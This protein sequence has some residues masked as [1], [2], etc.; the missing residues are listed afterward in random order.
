VCERE[1]LL[2]FAFGFGKRIARREKVGVQLV[3]AVGGVSE[4]ADL[5]CCLEG[6]AHHI[7]AR[8]DMSRPGH[9]AI[10]KLH[11]GPGLETPQSA[12]FDQVIAELAKTIY[13]APM[14]GEAGTG[15]HGQPYIRAA[16]SVAVAV[17]ETEI[18]CS[19]CDQGNQVSIRIHCRCSDL[20]QNVQRCQGCRVTHQRQIDQGLDRATPEPRPDTLV[21]MSCF[22]IRRMRRPVDAQMPQVIETDG[23][24]A[25]ALIE[26]RV[27]ID[28]QTR[29]SGSFHGI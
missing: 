16:R 29:D 10:S 20:G 19:A 2:G 28:A 25:A 12:S 6:A 9:D 24:G 11:I 8:P 14:I 17:L 5:V 22:L 1:A 13:G 18:D 26:G 27:Q 21:F 3:A 15:D 4:I 7:A 23:N